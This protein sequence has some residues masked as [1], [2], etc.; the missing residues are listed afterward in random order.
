MNCQN[1]TRC[2]RGCVNASLPLTVPLKRRGV[3]QTMRQACAL[4]VRVGGR[5]ARQQSLG[6]EPGI[7]S[8]QAKQENGEHSGEGL[9]TTAAAA[10]AAAATAMAARVAPSARLYAGRRSFSSL[11]IS[12][13]TQ[14]VFKCKNL[15]RIGKKR[16]K[17]K[18]QLFVSNALRLCEGLKS[19]G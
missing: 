10:A 11:L 17:E 5:G 15:K 16:E 19:A 8:L 14:Q 12:H 2:C 1:C 18:E 4:C 3:L 9:L 13:R 6:T 7:P